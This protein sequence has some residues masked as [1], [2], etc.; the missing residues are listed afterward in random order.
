MILRAGYRVRQFLAALGLF[1]APVDATAL[2][3]YLNAAQMELFQSMTTAEQRH[4]IAVL[5]TLQKAGHG[6]EAL[7]QAALLHDVG[8]V[9]GDIKLWHRVATV[10]L[11]T[12]CPALLQRLALDNPRSWRYPFFVQ[13][14]HAQRGAEMT[15]QAGTHPLAVALIRW[16]HTP[17]EQSSLDSRGQALLAALRAA[18]ETN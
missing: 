3:D 1:H 5:H 6:E 4:A 17:P 13:L 9:G 18:D 10:L 14:H 11:Q 8:K 12:I 16:H 15:A 7:V 2:T